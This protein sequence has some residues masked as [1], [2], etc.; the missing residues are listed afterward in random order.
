MRGESPG[1]GDSSSNGDDS[2]D[3]EL[4]V[5][6]ETGDEVKMDV[7]KQQFSTPEDKQDEGEE[8]KDE[9][10]EMGKS[11]GA[12][13]KGT[14]QSE[15]TR[16]DPSRPL[17][18]TMEESGDLK[19]EDVQHEGGQQDIHNLEHKVFCFLFVEIMTIKQTIIELGKKNWLN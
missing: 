11:T 19:M 14:E 13:S 1:S 18:S 15:R 12:D 6:E 16:E 9:G 7:S 10:N 2:L 3:N 4:G 17:K 8:E 5:E